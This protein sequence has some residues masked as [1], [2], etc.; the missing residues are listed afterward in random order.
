MPLALS[1][2]LAPPLG[3]GGWLGV[4]LALAAAAER[5]ARGALPHPEADARR[6]LRFRLARRLDDPAERLRFDVVR[7]TALVPGDHVLCV[8][9]DV[10]PAPMV[11]VAGAATLRPAGA[12]AEAPARPCAPGTAGAHATGGDHVASGWLV[13]RITAPADAADRPRRLSLLK[14]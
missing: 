9:G 10:V 3:L 7:A 5:M 11:A 6:E 8:A 2:T 14:T 1:S 12:P 13:A 4:V